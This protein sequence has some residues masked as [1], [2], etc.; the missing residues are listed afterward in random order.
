MN[1]SLPIIFESLFNIAYIIVIWIIV[2]KMNQNI[3]T[4]QPKNKIVANLFNLAFLLLAIGDTGHV[5]F[6]VVA[7]LLGGLDTS[8]HFF[9]IQ[10]SLVGLGM[11]ITAYTV[12][13]FYIILVFVWQFRYNKPSNF[14]TILL[15]A[16]GF[17]RLILMALPGNVWSVPSVK[18]QIGFIRNIPLFIQGAGIII[19]YFVSAHKTK[20]ALFRNIA[21]CILLSFAF[22]L[23]VILYAH[24]IP[25]IGTLMIPKTI[26]YVLV[27]IL[28]YQN[29]WHKQN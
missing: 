12:T 9:G 25:A 2:I 26:A 6:R 16:A 18:N 28:A 21:I 15:I 11:L 4:V 14:I 8:I 5:G 17:V 20:D 13:F 3:H 23:P 27:A 22:Y 19:L 29:I 24:T 1:K 10:M 7:Y